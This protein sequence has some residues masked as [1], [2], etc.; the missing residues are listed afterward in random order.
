MGNIKTARSV[1]EAMGQS[2]EKDILYHMILHPQI[3]PLDALNN[4]GCFRLGA[5]IY[6]LQRRGIR[7]KHTMITDRKTGKKYMAYSLEE[8]DA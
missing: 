1:C 3:T 5:R 2:Q 7:I 6:D 4:Y 8:D